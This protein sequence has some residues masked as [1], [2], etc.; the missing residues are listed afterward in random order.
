M[1]GL[2]QK[3]KD[4]PTLKKWA[5][6]A[7]QPK[8][9]YRPRW[10][11]R[12]LVNPFVHKKHRDAI[13]RWSVRMD[14]FPYKRFEIGAKSIIESFAMIANACGDVVIGEKVLIGLGCKITGP[15]TMGNH[16]LLAQNVLMSGL[17]HDFED[18]TKPIVAQGF[19]TREILIEDGVWIGGNAVITAGV[20]IGRNAIIGA[21]SVVTKDVPPYSVAVGNPARVVKQYNFDTGKWEKVGSKPVQNERYTVQR[22]SLGIDCQ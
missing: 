19:T 7:L 9:E 12:N 21:G 18:I 2:K 20:R 10:W 4:S 22:T 1:S 14:V 11:I 16:I 5:Q 6:W 13:I 3:I 15:V 17:N 8:N